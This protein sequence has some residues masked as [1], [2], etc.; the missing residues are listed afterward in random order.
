MTKAYLD[1]T[2]QR[3]GRWT[4]IRVGERNKHGQ[5][6]WTCRCD[7]GNERSIGMSRLRTGESQ[8]CGC[9]RRDSSRARTRSLSERFWSRV[10]T[11]GPTLRAELGPCHVWTGGCN[12]S[13]YGRIFVGGN[14]RRQVEAHRVAYF[15]ASGA[16]P[17]NEAMHRCDNPPCVRADHIVDGTH[18]DNMRDCASKGRR[19]SGMTHYLAKITDDD[20]RAIRA[21]TEAQSV[22]ASRYGIAQSAISRIQHRQ[23]WKHVA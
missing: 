19:P 8:S 1:L 17:A 22:L 14:G 21:S 20:V 6:M 3:F 12:S 5:A 11:N 9:L 13:G 2:G 4:A 23:T 16:W 10:D 7:C 15:L 18:A